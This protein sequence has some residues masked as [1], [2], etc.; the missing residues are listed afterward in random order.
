MSVIMFLIG[1][2][3][4]TFFLVGW[5]WEMREEEKNKEEYLQRMTRYYERYDIQRNKNPK[6]K[7][8]SQ[9]RLKKYNWKK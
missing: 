9:S 1:T 8:G 2:L 5:I 6:R 7:K 4:F 3:I